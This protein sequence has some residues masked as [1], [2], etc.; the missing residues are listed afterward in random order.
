MASVALATAMAPAATVAQHEHEEARPAVTGA[1]APR[2]SELMILQQIRHSKLWF[3]VAANNWE[4][5]EH[6]L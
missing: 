1:Y 4:L 6:G 3:A 5:A 2:L